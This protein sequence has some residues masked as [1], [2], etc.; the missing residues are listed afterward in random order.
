MHLP[1]SGA[2][3]IRIVDYR[4]EIVA[5]FKT[6]L[7]WARAAGVN[8]PED[9]TPREIE[10]NVAAKLPTVDSEALGA[11]VRSFEEA[12]YSLHPMTRKQYERMYLACNSLTTLPVAEPR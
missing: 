12:D 11:V 7:Q 1:A 2:Q 9:S 3:S 5:L 4:E 10:A 8:A 6:I